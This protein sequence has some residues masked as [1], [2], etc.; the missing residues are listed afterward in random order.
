MYQCEN[1]EGEEWLVGKPIKCWDSEHLKYALGL[2]LPCIVLWGFAVPLLVLLAMIKQT[3]RSE[4]VWDSFLTH[5]YQTTWRYWE[6]CTCALKFVLIAV[7]V[8]LGRIS[9]AFQ[10][11]VALAVLACYFVLVRSAS[12]YCYSFF[13]RLEAAGAL[14]VIA[15]LYSG[16][17][18][19]TNILGTGCQVALT[20]ATISL[21]ALYTGLC[22]RTLVMS[23]LSLISN[24]LKRYIYGQPLPVQPPTITI[25]T[26]V[27]PSVSEDEGFKSSEPAGLV[28]T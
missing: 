9:V 5:G 11:L 8:L 23:F 22:L 7:S 19:H 10:A 20:V 16:L 2:A 21:N 18:Y 3:N 15:T 14:T 4:R 17:C 27:H 26:R 1:I 13:T 24:K 6:F 28:F 25:D 12:P